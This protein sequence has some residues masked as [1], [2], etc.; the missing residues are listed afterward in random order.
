MGC[1][2]A[3]STAE[4]LGLGFAPFDRWD[5]VPGTKP[6]EGFLRGDSDLGVGNSASS[7]FSRSVVLASGIYLVC[8]WVG[9]GPSW[10]RSGR[11]LKLRSGGQVVGMSG[12]WLEAGRLI[13]EPHVLAGGDRESIYVRG[14]AA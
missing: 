4:S 6:A 7:L 5:S 12:S 2:P 10:R 13:T 8:F 1:D 14:D 9:A 3:R 11:R